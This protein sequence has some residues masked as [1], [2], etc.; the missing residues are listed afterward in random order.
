MLNCF[1]LLIKP[2]LL[3]SRECKRKEE[4]KDN[5]RANKSFLLNAFSGVVIGVE[6][7]FSLI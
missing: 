6:I 3:S 1:I 5:M 2:E 4:R 7:T